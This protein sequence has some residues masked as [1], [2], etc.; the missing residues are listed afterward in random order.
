[1]SLSSHRRPGVIVN[2]VRRMRTYHY[3]WCLHCQ[4]TVRFT[5]PNPF[6]T[7]CPHCFR[8]LSHELDVSR[9]RLQADHG[10]EPY[11]TTTRLFDTLAAA[12]DPL[13]RR[14]STNRRTRW[15]Q[16]GPEMRPMVTLVERPREQS[17]S[18][19]APQDT[20]NEIDGFIE[21][22]T[23]NDRPG[24]PP[25]AASA[26]EALPV[27]KITEN[28]LINVTHC[29][30]CRDEFKVDGEAKELPCKHL[31]HS[32]CI[33]PWLSIHNTCP[34]CR[35]EIGDDND[36]ATADDDQTGEMLFRDIGF[37]VD[38]LANGLTRLRTRFLSSGPLRAFSHWTHRY[39]DFL[40][41]RTNAS[42]LSREASSWWPSW[43]IL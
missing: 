19:V 23:G 24:P 7:Y 42:N 40:G 13:T 28:H 18:I 15:D 2:G 6:E 29:P 39:L 41:S 31:Y 16:S 5:N 1:M 37:V 36:T 27:V 10:L 43:F 17:S 21:G 32:D 25:A 12:L 14:Q 22:L 9:P 33:V 38:D 3:F 34:V 11:E 8:Q 4:R 30:V 20:G 26:I 35:Y